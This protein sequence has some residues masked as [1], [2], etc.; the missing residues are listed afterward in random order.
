MFS[1]V[2]SIRPAALI[3]CSPTVPPRIVYISF[4]MMGVTCLL[5]ASVGPHDLY[6]YLLLKDFPVCKSLENSSFFAVL[7]VRVEVRGLN[8]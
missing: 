8:I 7:G 3:L 6:I 5:H 4:I 1:V 2:A